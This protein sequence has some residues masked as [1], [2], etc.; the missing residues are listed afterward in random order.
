MVCEHREGQPAECMEDAVWSQHI[1]GLHTISL[2]L[3][4]KYRE[5]IMTLLLF[6]DLLD[7]VVIPSALDGFRN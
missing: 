4:F 7:Q 2:H 5:I 3:F 1:P 6:S